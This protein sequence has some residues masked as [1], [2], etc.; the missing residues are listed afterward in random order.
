MAASQATALAS[1]ALSEG[2]TT[3]NTP[4]SWRLE[5]NAPTHPEQNESAVAATPLEITL[6]VRLVNNIVPR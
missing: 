6:I 2:R 3:K 5:Q 1:S 4:Q